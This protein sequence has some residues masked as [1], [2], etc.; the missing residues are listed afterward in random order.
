MSENQFNDHLD[1][2]DLG[3]QV[4]FNNGITEWGA[5]FPKGVSLG[6][7][8]SDSTVDDNLDHWNPLTDEEKE[9]YITNREAGGN[10]NAL[11]W[12]GGCPCR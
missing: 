6:E 9:T 10:N 1:D 12:G 8:V 2:Y 3:N 4:R 11:G 5:I 7:G